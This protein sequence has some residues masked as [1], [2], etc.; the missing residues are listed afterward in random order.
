[1]TIAGRRSAVIAVGAIVGIVIGAA[2]WVS[3]GGLGE[4]LLTGAIPVAYAIVIF[5]LAR[6]SEVAGV[7]AG[8]FVDERA[9]HINLVATSWTV[10]ITAVLVLAAFVWA[11]ASGGS[12]QP[13]AFVAAVIALSYLGSL[14]VLQRRS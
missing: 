13:Y 12:W 9:E 6:R 10:G 5:F 7:L 4:T 2:V 8:Q 3:G 1:M 11:L 14:L